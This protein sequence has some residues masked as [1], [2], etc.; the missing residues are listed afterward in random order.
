M[1]STFMITPFAGAVFHDTVYF[2]DANALRL[3]KHDDNV[4]ASRQ[5]C[6]LY[7]KSKLLGISPSPSPG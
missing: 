5:K 7:L 1:N 4:N 3:R 6:R 2:I